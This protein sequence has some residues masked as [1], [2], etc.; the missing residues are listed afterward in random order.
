[1][2]RFLQ[3]GNKAAKYI[4]GGFLTLLALSMVI[5]LIPGLMSTTNA[6]TQS[7]SVATVAGVSIQREQVTKM[8]QQM[9]QA[10]ARGQRAD[11]LVPFMMQRAA[12]ELIQR[13]E[14]VYEAGRMGL[15]VSD[16]EVRDELQKGMYKEVFFPDG[17]WIGKQKYE[18]L[19]T[20]NGMTVA[21]FERNMRDDLLR[22]KLYYTIAAG[23][24]VPQSDVEKL[25]KD[26][27]LKVKFQ[28]AVLNVEDIQKQI[29]PTDSE[30]RAFYNTGRYNNFIPEK[31][32]IR[33]F[34][35]EDKDAQGKVA[36]DPTEVQ[37][38]YNAHQDEFR[39]P[40]RVRARH[41]L[42]TTPAVKPGEKPDQKVIDEARAKAADVLKQIKA[43][44]DFAELAKKYSQDDSG[45]QGGE[46]GW[47]TRGGW[48]KPFE[49]VAFAKSP[50]QISNLV[51]SEYGFHIIQTEEKE[52]ARLKPLSEVKS[53]IEARLK[54]ADVN[55]YLTKAAN[56]S[57]D[58]AQR[59]SL[60]KAAAQRGA[61][62]VQSNLIGR[63]DQLPGIGALPP[64]MNAIFSA[65]E[66]S[67][68]SAARYSQGYVLFEV[69]KI[70]PARTPPIEE[71][72]DRVTSDFKASQANQ[73][74]EKKTHAM[75]ERAHA[76]HDLAKAAKEAGATLKT[77]DLVSRTSQVG[78]LGPIAGPLS[79]AFDLK[80]G[81]ISGP[82]SLTGKG[83]VLQVTDRQEPSLADPQ[84]AAERDN[85]RE[86]LTERKREE[87]VE[88]F[89]GDLRSR[90]EKEG[91]IKINKTEMDNLAGRPRS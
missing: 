82:L 20:Q 25:Y 79:A 88:L 72:K 16:Q 87:T 1:M 12:Q 17:K 2:I 19:F 9:A 53:Q 89:M 58:L 6:N 43:G 67:G 77:G 34:L 14:V 66:K 45:K 62:V 35:L 29:K 5:Y 80:P 91:K 31:R 11:F 50:G 13:E 26:K 81:E 78:D 69:S 44:G 39:T 70:V 4:L 48:V 30:L 57:Q 18:E 38:Y 42:I 74:L 84:F 86:Q 55:K 10:Q 49:D 23:V 37:S 46:L 56:E 83:V 75:A 7:G 63:N 32:Q 61:Q 76:E 33:Y 54:P 15:M 90:L 36:V 64:L 27:N 3:S 68:P 73:L 47:A 85:L 40:E 60:D 22:R 28:Y 41:I 71:I 24:T 51:Q 52:A 65:T 21:E 8:A 59:E